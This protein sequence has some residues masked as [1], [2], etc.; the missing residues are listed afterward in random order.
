M[1]LGSD[2]LW[3]VGSFVARECSNNGLGGG[4]RHDETKGERLEVTEGLVEL[5]TLLGRE[6]KLRICAGKFDQ[7]RRV[8][9]RSNAS[10]I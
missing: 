5:P 9:A 10:V 4:S 6:S 3:D 1:S 7:K 8:G 2:V